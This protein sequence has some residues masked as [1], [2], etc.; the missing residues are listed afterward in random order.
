MSGCPQSG[1]FLETPQNSDD[2]AK[3]IR[4]LK[5]NFDLGKS[6]MCIKRGVYVCDKQTL[7]TAYKKL[8]EYRSGVNDRRAELA[9][10]LAQKKNQNKVP[11]TTQAAPPATKKQAAPPTAKKNKRGTKPTNKPSGE[12]PSES[13]KKPSGEA[14]SE[15]PEEQK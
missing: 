14:P 11:E 4:W 8:Q 1:R 9:R 3:T 15:S 7:E 6:I 5:R 13:P 12:A 2:F 10:G